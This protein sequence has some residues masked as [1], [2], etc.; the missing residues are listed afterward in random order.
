MK[1]HLPIYGRHEL[2]VSSLE[3]AERVVAMNF[4][5]ILEFLD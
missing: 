4:P 2:V 1:C 3:Q 5:D